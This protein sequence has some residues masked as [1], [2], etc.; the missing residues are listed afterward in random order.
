MTILVIALYCK[1]KKIQATQTEKK[2]LAM[3]IQGIL[4]YLH[5]LVVMAIVLQE[6]SPKLHGL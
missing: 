1:L 2:G 4:W 5:L 3:R 6:E